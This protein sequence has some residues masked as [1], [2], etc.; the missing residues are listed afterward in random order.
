MLADNKCTANELA[1][2]MATIN[3]NDATI[4]VLVVKTVDSLLM[5]MDVNGRSYLTECATVDQ[6][7]RELAQ[8]A[9]KQLYELYPTFQE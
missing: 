5:S 8:E 6:G 1:N 9:H 3:H 7:L 4:P 2:S